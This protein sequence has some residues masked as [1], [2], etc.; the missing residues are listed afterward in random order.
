MIE[1]IT[2]GGQALLQS[3]LL[4]LL[5]TCLAASARQQ[6]LFKFGQNTIR[7]VNILQNLAEPL[8][9]FLLSKVGQLTLT[10]RPRATVIGVFRFLDFR[11]DQA[12]VIRTFQQSPERKIML[13]ISG[14][15]SPL[16][17]RFYKEANLLHDELKAAGKPL[18]STSLSIYG[19]DNL[20]PGSEIPK[21]AILFCWLCFWRFNKTLAQLLREYQSGN[22]KATK[23]VHKLSLEYDAWRFGQLDPNK[24]KFKIDWDHFELITAGLGLGV[25]NLTAIELAD[26]FDAVCPCGKPHFPENLNKLRTRIVKAFPPEWNRRF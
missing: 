3:L 4:L 12:L 5:K 7:D 26:C 11:S 8:T 16:N 13:A 22:M 1:A 25:E 10:A 18:Y 24:L 2:N 6:R 23:Q 20:P 17:Y 19:A 15:V 21:E 14:L 9:Q